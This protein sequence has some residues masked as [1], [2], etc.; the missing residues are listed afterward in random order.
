MCSV[1]TTPGPAATTTDD[2]P[3]PIEGQ[4]S[5]PYRVFQDVYA[6]NG[7]PYAANAQA[8]LQQ[9]LYACNAS[10]TCVGF[11]YDA[12]RNPRCSHHFN[13]NNLLPENVLPRTGNVHYRFDS[14]CGPRREFR[15]AYSSIRVFHNA[16]L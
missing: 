7:V 5:G 2:T 11:D 4:C 14:T 13:S 3:A 9:C 6:R 1:Q 12:S 10:M 15:S 16:I 8:T